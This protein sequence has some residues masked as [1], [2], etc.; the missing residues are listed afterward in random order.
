MVTK[1]QTDK[2]NKFEYLF[3]ALA[4]CISRFTACRPVLTIDG[5]HFKGKYKGILYVA[6]TMDDNQQ[7]YPIA[8]GL[9]N[10][11]NDQGWKLFLKELCNVIRSPQD[12]LLIFDRHI[13]IKNTVE[14]VFSDATHDLS[15]FHMKRNL[16]KYKNDKVTNIF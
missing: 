13:S 6:T 1:I 11:E 14:E 16:K 15:D 7:I 3:M 2:E 10:L 12:L 8:F 4:L 5:T 9:G